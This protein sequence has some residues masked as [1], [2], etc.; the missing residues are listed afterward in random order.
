MEPEL[1]F[2]VAEKNSIVVV[3]I[4]GTL[5]RSGEA[6]LDKCREEVVNRHPKHVILYFKDLGN[7]ADLSAFPAL[8]R[9]QKAIRDLP[10][11][12]R[13]C[14]LHPELRKFLEQKGLLRLSELSPGLPEALKALSDL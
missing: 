14:G 4:S 6:V 9:L 12:L 3:S 7:R 11:S 10:A 2:F 1:Q 13:L 5:S 8:A